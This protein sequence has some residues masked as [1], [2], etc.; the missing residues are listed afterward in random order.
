MHQGTARYDSRSGSPHRGL[1]DESSTPTVGPALRPPS[2]LPD[3][4]RPKPAKVRLRS[5]GRMT[6]AKKRQYQRVAAQRCRARKAAEFL[7]LSR[8]LEELEAQQLEP[9][10]ARCL[11]TLRVQ[12]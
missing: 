6:E 4:V 7:A 11:Q 3:E 12:V 9:T 5:S 10:G 2:V 1:T 8:R